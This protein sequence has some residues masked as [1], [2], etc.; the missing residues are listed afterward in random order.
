MWSNKKSLH[1]FNILV[2]IVLCTIIVESV[3]KNQTVQATPGNLKSNSI[4]TCNGITYGSHGDGHWH[5]AQ[6]ESGYW[7]AIGEPVSTTNPCGS[8][9]EPTPS[10]T[11]TT[12]QQTAPVTQQTTPVQSTPITTNQTTPTTTTNPQP[13]EPKKDNNTAIKEIKVN[14]EIVTPNTEGIYSITVDNN[15]VNIDVKLASDKATYKLDEMPDDFSATKPAELTL[16]VTAEDGTTKDY[17]IKIE[18]KKED[19]VFRLWL[20][21]DSKPIEFKNDEY[22]TQDNLSSANEFYFYY[23][24]APEGA[25]VEVTNN[26]ELVDGMAAKLH[27][28]ENI[29]EFKI[30]TPYDQEKTFKVFVT[31]NPLI[32]NIVIM[33]AKFLA[34]M[35]ISS[36]VGYFIKY[37]L[38]A[39]KK[40]KSAGF[41]KYL[42]KRFSHYGWVKII[43]PLSGFSD[44]KD[45]S[46]WLTLYT[47]L[48]IIMLCVSIVNFNTYDNPNSINSLR[49]NNDSAVI[50]YTD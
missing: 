11:T 50:K 28:G 38:R 32:L 27:D 8:V 36:I 16:T 10:T 49:R 34:I 31:K 30:K 6:F 26:G 15:T 4:V 17:K 5:V 29:I 1:I 35:L 19:T 43:F 18:R 42:K 47:I 22:Q 39:S 7:H 40:E 21:N 14:N 3:T 24:V 23:E 46:N 44:K 37:L 33:L 25:S 2:G 45:T 41:W 9:S 13:D 12:P 48:W 20:K